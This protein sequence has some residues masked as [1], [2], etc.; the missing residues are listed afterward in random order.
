MGRSNGVK[1]YLKKNNFVNIKM[2]KDLENIRLAIDVSGII[3]RSKI[4]S[5][6]KWWLQIINLMNKFSNYKIKPVFV[7]DGKPP[8]EKL[9]IIEKRINK[10]DKI[11]DKIIKKL[12]DTLINN[13]DTLLDNDNLIKINNL[14]KQLHVITINDI[15]ICKQICIYFGIPFIHIKSLEADDIFSYLIERGFVDGVYS[16]DNDMFRRGC[17]TVYFGLDYNLNK[18]YEFIYN[19]CLDRMNITIEQFNNAYDSAGTDYGTDNLEYCK[20]KETIELIRRYTTIENVILNLDEINHGKTSR[21]IKV[22]RQFDYLKVR[23][24]FDRE[25]SCKIIKEINDSVYKFQY[26]TDNVKINLEEYSQR[27][28]TEINNLYDID[29]KEAIKYIQQSKDYYRNVYGIQI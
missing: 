20:F 14:S 18:L 2:L 12:N 25:L 21:I 9:E 5:N 17:K 13:E 22:P 7:F 3:H 24:I 10:K 23:E 11:I 27:L 29:K 6:I 1:E 15:E 28:F 16:E 4:H 19:E 8:N 26:I